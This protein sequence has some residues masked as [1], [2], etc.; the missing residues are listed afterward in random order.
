MRFWSRFNEIPVACT[1]STVEG[2]VKESPCGQDK[3]FHMFPTRPCTGFC[4]ASGQAYILSREQF[5]P[6]PHILHR[7]YYY[8]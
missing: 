3:D 8:Y 5:N 2:D 7:S 1:V 6:W 4:A